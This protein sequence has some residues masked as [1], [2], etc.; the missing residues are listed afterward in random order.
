[1]KKNSIWL[2]IALLAIL[3]AG[4]AA[5][6]AAAAPADVIR[7][8]NLQ[9]I[10]HEQERVRDDSGCFTGELRRYT[11]Y[12]NTA[13]LV[14]EGSA[15]YVTFPIGGITPELRDASAK[16]YIDKIVTVRN[17]G[18]EA[19]FVRTYVAVPTGGVIGT[20]P[21]EGN[22]IH[23]DSTEDRYGWSWGLTEAWPEGNSGWDK[24]DDAVINGV[25]YDI[26]I[27]TY[28]RAISPGETTPPNLLGFYVDCSVSNDDGCGYFYLRDGIKTALHQTMPEVLVAT[29]ATL[30]AGFD[31]PRTALNAVFGTPDLD[32]HPWNN[33][34]TVYIHSNEELNAALA[35]QNPGAVLLLMDGTYTLPSELPDGLR[36]L[37]Y[38]G[39][40]FLH[41]PDVLNATALKLCHVTVDGSFS[42]HGSGEF[43]GV[44]FLGLF[45][46]AFTGS[47]YITDCSFANP[48][49]WYSTNR[50]IPASV[51][52]ENCTDG[53][54]NPI[55]P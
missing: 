37:G 20:S 50:Q 16:N 6:H 5:H 2:L 21:Y 35:E 25:L 23:W 33:H 42:F 34:T 31:D 29:Q 11:H 46:A 19:A 48:P 55:N 30:A 12:Q 17:A 18:S 9:V 15:G 3:T 51:L 10:Q 1:M 44:A 28:C 40:V 32:N 47:S 24:I 54:G 52:Y 43:D 8:G 22:W 53:D 41:V 4:F 7:D 36:I 45:D 49:V 14:Q 27:A 39:N 13:P 38:G 26:Y